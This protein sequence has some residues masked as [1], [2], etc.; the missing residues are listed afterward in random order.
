MGNERFYETPVAAGAQRS[1]PAALRNREPIASVLREWLPPQG[2]VLEIASGTGEHCIY[3]AEAFP[4]LE[5]Q[6][7]D[8]HPDALASIH[9]WLR[10]AAPSNVR[11][12][13]EL[14]AAAA[15]WPATSADA[16]LCINML[17][18]SPWQSALGLLEG[19]AKLLPEQSPLILY[20]P[21]I[22]DGVETAPSNLE[23]DRNLKQRDSRWGLRKV[24]DFAAAASQRG[25][26]LAEIRTMPA[27]NV[28]LLLRRTASPR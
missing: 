19:A 17:H 5:W 8:A 10:A 26:E 7:T 18:I 9:A 6:P 16:I 11:P 3:F 14:D 13:L 27:N 28:M 22:V 21:W 15:D 4:Q 1:A 20:G 2:L 23:F 12:P 25:F 24:G